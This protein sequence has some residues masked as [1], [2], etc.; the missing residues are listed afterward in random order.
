MS[1]QI[2]INKLSI[3]R[4]L[5]NFFTMFRLLIGLPLVLLLSKEQYVFAWLL[6]LFSALSDFLDGWFARKANDGENLWGAK[7]D[8]LA[9]KLLL[10]APFL[11]LVYNHILP[12]W[13]VWLLLARELYISNWRSS[14]RKGAPASIAGKLKTSIQFLSI[15]LMIWPNHWGDQNIV[16]L[17]HHI[18]F[19]L[20]W[21]SLILALLSG[22]KY[23]IDEE[24]DHLN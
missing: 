15:L 14:H 7:F 4:K 19:L 20:F 6:F 23:L 10:A 9:D 22:F 8:P 12:I 5:A 21:P 2:Y 16:N 13:S 3:F 1:I 11:W 17:F 24:K 18:G